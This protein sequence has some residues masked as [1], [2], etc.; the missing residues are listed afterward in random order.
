MDNTQIEELRDAIIYKNA[1]MRNKKNITR[2]M[3]KPRM[4]A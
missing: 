2:K 3:A 4:T 1:V